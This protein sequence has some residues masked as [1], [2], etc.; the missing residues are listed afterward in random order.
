VVQYVPVRLKR[1]LKSFCLALV[2]IAVP[3]CKADAQREI[4]LSEVAKEIQARGYRVQQSSAPAPKDWEVAKFRMRHKVQVSFKAQERLPN[5]NENYYV[6]FTLVEETYDSLSDA[7]QR[8][9]QLHDRSPDGGP[10]DQYLSVL[11]DGFVVDRN[12]YVLQTDAVKFLSEI[13]R[14]TKEL[15]A[16]R[17][18][19][20][21]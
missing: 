11:R 13:Q 5:E 3:G 21:H 8:F 16:A 7:Q 1:I 4:P 9:A 18:N 15:A 6:R 14:L 20:S 10:E 2:L 19:S 12:L 17:A